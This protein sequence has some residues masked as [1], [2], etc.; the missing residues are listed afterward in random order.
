MTSRTHQRLLA[1]S[2]LLVVSS[3][4]ACGDPNSA[5]GSAGQPVDTRG[6]TDS[7]LG[8]PPPASTVT[9]PPPSGLD[10]A[11]TVTTPLNRNVRDSTMGSLCW[12]RRAVVLTMVQQY[13]GDGRTVPGAAEQSAIVSALEQ[14]AR[15]V[16]LATPGLPPEVA[17]FAE[18]F[19]A[20]LAGGITMFQSRTVK[21]DEALNF[22]RFEEYPDAEV[23]VRLA[24]KTE[25]CVDI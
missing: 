3:L 19:S 7:S 4:S 23:F 6:T 11:P 10:Q 14:S 21:P 20:D 18:R 13:V 17:K 9:P 15:E 5:Q 12:A 22:F 16:S 8:L 25:N 1:A 24:G 2:L